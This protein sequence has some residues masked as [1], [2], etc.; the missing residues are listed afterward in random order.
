MTVSRH[1]QSI[2]NLVLAERAIAALACDRCR[3]CGCDFGFDASDVP[4]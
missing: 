4:A 3:P 2:G 1:Y